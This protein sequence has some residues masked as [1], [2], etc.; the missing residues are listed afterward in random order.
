MPTDRGRRSVLGTIVAGGFGLIAAAFAGLFGLAAVPRAAAADKRWRRAA[1]MFDLGPNR[2]ME[3]LLSA[4]HEDGWFE[5]RQQTV[6]FLDSD[7]AGGYRAFSSSCTHLGCRVQW[8]DTRKLYAC[9]CH[10]GLFARDG[11]V[12]GGPPPRPLDA[13]PVRLNEQTSDL[14]VEL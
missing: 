12:A 14:E 1:S 2:P 4:R 10:G 3:V 9:P 5:T 8:D 13:V 11:T 6:I 7:G